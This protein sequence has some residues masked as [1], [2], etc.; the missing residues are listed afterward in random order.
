M[1]NC[2]H[3]LFALL[4]LAVAPCLA[5]CEFI[6]YKPKGASPLAP[7]EL[8]DDSA[9][10]E[11]VF[12]RFPVGEP[13][14]TQLWKEIDE[15]AI[16]SAL[17]SELAAN[18][19]RAGLIGGETPSVLARKLS[20]PDEKPNP[21]A[22][23]AKLE[24]EPSVRRSHLQI[25]RGRPGNIVV[26]AVYDQLSLL[27]REDGQLTGK[28]YPQAQGDFVIT[29]DPQPD[30]RVLL[31][32]VPELKYGEPRRE[33]VAEDGIFHPQLSKPKKTFD[34]LKLDTT[35]A[36]DQMLVL[37][38]MPERPGSLGQKFFT[39]AKSG[40]EEQ[41]LLIIRLHETKRS[42]LFVQVSEGSET[43]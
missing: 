4:A 29:V 30:R 11:V 3:S 31:S 18:G 43:R 33:Y 41:K 8:T 38:G 36:A 15:Q 39:E 16:S 34:K 26:S 27:I 10:L 28:P 24:T 7:L 25:H 12:I 40:Q 35:L 13:E 1:Q 14:M 32:L 42:D 9:E 19:L 6:S 17:R 2:A 20:T 21:A 5:G 22:A 23:A 37:T